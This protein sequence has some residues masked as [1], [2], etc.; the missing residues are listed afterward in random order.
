VSRID[1]WKVLL[2]ILAVVNV[3][4]GAWMLA[5]PSGWYHGIPAAVPDTGP[6]NLHFVRDV[7]GIYLTMGVALFWAGARPADRLALVSMVLLFHLIH[8]G[9]HALD[10]LDGRLPWSHWA[11]DYPGVYLPTLVLAAALPL[12]GVAK[13]TESRRSS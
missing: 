3:G 10:T 7:G 9:A 12:L 11:I 1:R 8:A 2:W 13:A 4:N 6:L 5:D